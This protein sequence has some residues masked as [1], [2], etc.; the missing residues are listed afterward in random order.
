M[1]APMQQ[2]HDHGSRKAYPNMRTPF[3]SARGGTRGAPSGSIRAGAKDLSGAPMHA[4]ASS[5]HRGVSEL[6]AVDAVECYI[7]LEC[8]FRR[9]YLHM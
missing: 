3:L 9:L 4:A 2:R 7:M 1:S 8:M 5:S 6:S